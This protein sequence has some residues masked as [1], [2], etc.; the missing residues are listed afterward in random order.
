MASTVGGDAEIAESDGGGGAG[1]DDAGVAEA[2]EGDEEA[3]ASADGGVELVRDGAR[4]GAGG[5][6]RW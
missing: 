2:D 3:D 5:C 4:R 1:N 6:R